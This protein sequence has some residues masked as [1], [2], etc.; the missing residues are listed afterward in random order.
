[1]HYGLPPYILE[2]ADVLPE[3]VV[4]DCLRRLVSRSQVGDVSLIRV[5]NELAARAQ[6]IDGDEV[7]RSMA[8][9]R[10]QSTPCTPT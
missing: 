10:R 5:F 8:I 1:M 6:G 7:M 3:I 2:V 4:G 9:G